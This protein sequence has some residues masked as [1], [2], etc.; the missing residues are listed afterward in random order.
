M[1]TTI[2]T[3]L[4][5]A[6]FT[7]SSFC[8]TLGPAADQAP[9]EIK[10]A[11]WNLE[12][13]FD[14]DQSDNKSPLAK[15]LSAPTA[16]DWHW[17]RDEA[18]RVI[19]EM[20]PTILALQEIENEKVVQEL[21]EVLK[22]KYGLEYQ[23][24]FIKGRDTFTEQDV[25]FM[26][27]SGF[28]KCER[29]EQTK[30]M[31]DSKQ[32]YNLSKHLFATFRWTTPTGQQ[33][34][35]ICNVHLR[36]GQ[37]GAAPRLRQC[38]LLQH[39]TKPMIANDE[40]VIVIGDINTSCVCDNVSAGD[41]LALLCGTTGLPSSSSLFDLHLKLPSSQ[42][43]THMAGKQFDHVLVSPALLADTD[44]EHDLIFSSI[45]SAKQLV[46]NG[47]QDT[48]HYNIFYSI[49]SHERDVSDHYP[50]VATF[51]IK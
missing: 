44:S 13:F 48:D 20:K 33:T 41:D 47:K 23:V 4:T 8:C 42:R 22:T 15:K 38:R 1:R 19:A 10:I 24:A 2:H 25:A 11:T 32:Y 36:A 7:V 45:K 40:N 31:Y 51:K 21:A 16:A 43:T 39:W 18:A 46:I 27:T 28:E 26:Y 12:W 6:I 49:P 5:L 17:K 14:H 30:T 35:T 3:V 37:R 9:A 50:V 34:L 29:R